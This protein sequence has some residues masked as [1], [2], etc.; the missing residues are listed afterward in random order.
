[1]SEDKEASQ[2]AWQ[3]NHDAALRAHASDREWQVI[4]LESALK[5][6]VESIKA[7]CLITGGAVVVGLAFVGS[8]YGTEPMLAKA[9]VTPIFL[10]A[11]SA[12]SAALCAAFAYV[13]QWCYAS[14]AMAK[15]HG[16][17]HPYVEQKPAS[18]RY[19]RIG[20]GVH[21]ISVLFAVGAFV[22]MIWGGYCAWAVL[23]G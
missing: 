10:L 20:G 18:K 5:F 17:K 8:I 9:L 22:F 16:W 15:D 13:A 6:A 14:G 12:V 4:M 2:V 19:N 3:I 1:M 11:A 23:S 21:V 7:I